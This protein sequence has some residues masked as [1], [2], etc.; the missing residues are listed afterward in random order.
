MDFEAVE[1]PSGRLYSVRIRRLC[2]G[3]DDHKCRESSGRL[4]LIP[5]EAFWS[6]NYDR[7]DIQH[8][9]TGE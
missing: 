8:T 3:T 1:I 7:F 4:W 5:D 9:K 2:L 6:K